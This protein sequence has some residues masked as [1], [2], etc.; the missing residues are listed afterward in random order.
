MV[1]VEW[2]ISASA[3]DEGA[4]PSRASGGARLRTARADFFLDPRERLTEQERAL[5]T[6]MLGDLVS[7]LADEFATLMPESEPANDGGD[8][9]FD[10]L[11]SAGLLDLADLVQLLLRRAEEER[12]CAAIRAGRLSGKSRVL[13]SLVSDPDTDVSAAAMALILARGRRRDRFDGPRITFDDLP[14]EAAVALVSAIAAALRGGLARRSGEKEADERLS[15]AAQALLARHDEGNRLDARLFALV[16]A[17]DRAGKL[18]DSFIRSAL[19]EA[20]VS[21]LAEILS[22]RAGLSVDSTWNHLAGGEGRLALLSRLA[23]L[24]RALAG[25]VIAA[26]AEVVGTD[27][28]KEIQAF[29]ALTGEDVEGARSWLRLNPVYRDAIGALGKGHGERAF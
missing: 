15:A 11:W 4:V 6:A 3:S 28:E 9:L 27:A 2:P 5:M 25:E 20:E 8:R 7:S 26:F 1:P 19:A 18:D 29:D 24:H 10:R 23:S 17:L 13:Q 22:R 14:A 16:H 12:L 21:L